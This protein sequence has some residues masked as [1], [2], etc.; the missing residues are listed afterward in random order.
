MTRNATVS[1]EPKSGLTADGALRCGRWRRRIPMSAATH[2]P[3]PPA[4]AP[5]CGGRRQGWRR[6]GGRRR[7]YYRS[8]GVL[9]RVAGFTR[10]R[11]AMPRRS[12]IRRR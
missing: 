1:G 5:D 7:D 8:L 10:R 2:L 6:H 4:A 12:P 9:N 11:T 3:Q